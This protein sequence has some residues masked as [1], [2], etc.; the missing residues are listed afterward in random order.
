M[1]HGVDDRKKKPFR[2]KVMWVGEE[3][4]AQIIKDSWKIADRNSMMEVMGLIKGYS[5]KLKVW[6]RSAFG[7]VKYQLTK[8]RNR[9]KQIA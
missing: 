6:N 3:K 9:L 1:E 5:E 4:C 2:S 8:A 7:N